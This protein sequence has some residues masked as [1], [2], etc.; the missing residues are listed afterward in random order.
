MNK[1]I[2][3]KNF[4]ELKNKKF[5]CFDLIVTAGDEVGTLRVDK[6]MGLEEFIT[7]HT[8]I[9]TQLGDVLIFG[10]NDGEP[11]AFMLPIKSIVSIEAHLEEEKE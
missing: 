11:S 3:I 9:N 8:I 10:N 4:G 7:K 5:N 2:T 6:P 1:G